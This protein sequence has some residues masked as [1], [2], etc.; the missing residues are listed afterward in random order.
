MKI[1]IFQGGLGNQIFHY[2]FY[3]YVINNI[4]RKVFAVVRDGNNHNGYEID[5]YFDVEIKL[6]DFLG[7]LVVWLDHNRNRFRGIFR[8]FYLNE[9][10]RGNM[11]GFIYDGYWQNKKYFMNTSIKFRDLNLSDRNNVIKTKC[12]VVIVLRSI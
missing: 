12:C 1:V 8:N 6:S 5:R 4:D 10:Q 7:K 11:L 3:Q 2:L 9:F